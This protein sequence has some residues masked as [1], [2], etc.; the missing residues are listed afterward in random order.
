[1]ST[2]LS[3]LKRPGPGTAEPTPLRLRRAVSPIR[4]GTASY[5][6][7]LLPAVL[8]L[9]VFSLYPL[10]GSV[11]AFKQ[12]M[13][14]KG[15]WGSPWAG[16]ENFEIVFS[17]PTFY[18]IIRNTLF[19]SI[20]KILLDLI[21]PLVFALALNE[22]RRMWFRRIVQTAA[23]LPYFLSWVILAGVFKDILSTTGLVNKL[24]GLAF[25]TQP[26]MFF[27]SV[28]AFPYIVVLTDTWK[29]YGFNAIIYLAA[30]ASIDMGLYEAAMIDGA[31]RWKQL[32]A[33]TLPGLAATIT[34]LAALSLQN[35]LNAGFEQIL[36]L[37]NPL[38]Y[39]SGDILDTYVYR[40]GLID[41]QFEVATAIGLMKS[42]VGFCLIYTANTLAERYANYRVF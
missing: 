19:I 17:S 25:R 1:V 7:M 21:I 15:I 29:N 18:R 8:F 16:L 33:V 42:L 2:T 27:A 39:E 22:E 9:C 24:L 35:V 12:Y 3:T 36:N 31:S 10:L 11:L 26:V 41:S 20:M 5:H 38:V 4:H 23:Y 28:R 40:M 34:L 30:L 14:S 6:L 32:L 37:Y 13:P